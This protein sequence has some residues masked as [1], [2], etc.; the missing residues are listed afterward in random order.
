MKA[1]QRNGGANDVTEERNLHEAHHDITEQESALEQLKAAE[2]KYRMV[3]ENASEAI[4]V[5]QDGQ[6]K[7]WNRQLCA[8]TGFADDT[9]A[10]LEFADFVHPDDLTEVMQHYRR[11]LSGEEMS[12]QYNIRLL[13]HHGEAKWVIVHSVQI[14]WEG[15]PASLVMLT[16]ITERK[17]AEIDLERVRNS[18]AEA[19]RIAHMGSWEWGIVTGELTWSDEVY[20][21]FGLLPQSCDPTYTMFMEAVHPDDR[22]TVEQAVSAALAG[23]VA[24][25]AINHRVVRP[26]GTERVVHERGEVL[27]EDGHPVTMIGTVQD[28]TTIALLRHEA[29]V[30]RDALARVNRTTSMEKLAGSIAHELNQPLTGI[31]SNAQAGEMM[32]ERDLCS[33]DEMKTVISEIVSDAKRAGDVI[34]NLRDIYR[35]QDGELVPVDVVAL[36][37]DTVS[38]LH[39]EFVLQEV[40]LDIQVPDGATVVK[41]NR[42]Q[43]QQVLLNLL[44]N[45]VEAMQGLEQ[46]A[47]HLTISVETVADVAAVAVADRG[48]GIG[49]DRLPGIFEPLATWKPGGTGMG[50]AISASIIKAHG[51]RMWAEDRS[52]GGARVGFRIPLK[53]AGDDV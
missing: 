35:K 21:I 40:N 37:Q 42:V 52:E 45:A 3:V 41:G 33:C 38:M 2:E 24:G 46:A 26:D 15:R 16:D 17:L 18:L 39:S 53:G 48:A 30:Q 4:A 36:V 9:I 47:R 5:S 22:S 29:D 13:T 6:V 10:G 51:G 32:I 28:V 34:R 12:A 1:G 7:F 19:Q 23:T 25:Y 11:R 50:L 20:R 44:S 27:R 14:D 43:L 8:L 49:A 31:L